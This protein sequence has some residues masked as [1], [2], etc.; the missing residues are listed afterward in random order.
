MSEKPSEKG[1][2]MFESLD[3]P[4]FEFSEGAGNL[5]R[6]GPE[7]MT[8]N[9]LL[10][11]MRERIKYYGSPIP[12]GYVPP[13]GIDLADLLKQVPWPPSGK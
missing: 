13:P 11:L 7:P 1:K 8:A 12:D 4:L 2:T 3:S 5:T 6:H 9:H 10:H